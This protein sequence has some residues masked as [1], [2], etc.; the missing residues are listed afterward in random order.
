MKLLKKDL[1][2]TLNTKN[3]DLSEVP[4]QCIFNDFSFLLNI[5][6]KINLHVWFYFIVFPYN[7][8]H[9]LRDWSHE[10]ECFALSECILLFFY[11]W[12]F[13][14]QFLGWKLFQVDTSGWNFSGWELFWVGTFQAF[15]YVE[16]Q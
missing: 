16:Y 3:P 10:V 15:I 4:F 1:D 13:P 12:N 9:H 11:S 5:S 8:L 7:T 2:L 14:P 6:M